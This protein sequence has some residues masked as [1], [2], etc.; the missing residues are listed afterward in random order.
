MGAAGGTRNGGG[1]TLRLGIDGGGRWGTAKAEFRDLRHFTDVI[2]AVYGAVHSDY[3]LPRGC[4]TYFLGL[5]AEYDYTWSDIL[6]IQNKSD[7]QD[8]NLMVS[9]GVRY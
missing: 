1:Q 4:C 7:V 3:E 8:I 9:L 5:R 2:G 6:Q